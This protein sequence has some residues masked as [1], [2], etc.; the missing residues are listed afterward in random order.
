MKKVLFGVFAFCALFS[1]VECKSIATI[2]FKPAYFYP[3]DSVFRD[4]YSGGFL[5]LGEFSIYLSSNAFISVEAG[6]FHKS[7]YITSVNI[8]SPTS[9]TNVPMSCYLG[10]AFNIMKFWDFYAKIGPNLIYTKTYAEI[11][12]LAKIA[13]TNSFGGSF[14][15]GTKFYVIKGLFIEIFANYLYNKKQIENSGDIFDVYF[16]GLQVGGG[17]GWRF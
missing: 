16:G 11:P 5:P 3:Q 15:L 2:T 17:L 4:I 13:K 9:V 12:G 6:C 7:T 14:A 8:T 10:Y 1:V